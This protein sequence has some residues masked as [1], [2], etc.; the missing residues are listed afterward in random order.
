MGD[1]SDSSCLES[2]DECEVENQR[3]DLEL[4]R[5]TPSLASDIE[6][7]LSLAEEN[8]AALEF[9]DGPIKAFPLGTPGGPGGM[10]WEVPRNAGKFFTNGGPGGMGLFYK[11]IQTGKTLERSESE[12]SIKRGHDES[13]EM[14]EIRGKYENSKRRRSLSKAGDSGSKMSNMKGNC[15]SQGEIKRGCRPLNS[16]IKKSSRRAILISSS[17]SEADEEEQP[18]RDGKVASKLLIISSSEE[19]DSNPGVI[20]RDNENNLIKSYSCIRPG[21]IS[22][23]EGVGNV[24]RE[25]GLSRENSISSPSSEASLEKL[26]GQS[27][28]RGSVALP[29]MESWVQEE[30]DERIRKKNSQERKDDWLEKVLIQILAERARGCEEEGEK[31]LLLAAKHLVQCKNCDNTRLSNGITC[32]H[33]CY[34][35]NCAHLDKRLKVIIYVVPY[36]FHSGSMAKTVGNASSRPEKM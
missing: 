3:M 24:L 16:M 8:G 19:E 35:S 6:G 32:C 21:Q 5:D 23:K 2:E 17:S 30:E 1:K 29:K 12:S 26:P 15:G 13:E 22:T 33:I 31:S 28:V 14:F 10:G 7:C 20:I 27:T 36:V 25:S 18:K 34:L 9:S 11:Q 4:L